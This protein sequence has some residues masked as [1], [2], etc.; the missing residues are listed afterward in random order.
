MPDTTNNLNLEGLSKLLKTLGLSGGEDLNSLI[1]PKRKP[2][3]LTTFL[4]PIMQL[5]GTTKDPNLSSSTNK[6]LKLDSFTKGVAS[7]A[8]SS[9]NPYAMAAGFGMSLIDNTFGKGSKWNAGK[10]DKVNQNI[11]G[12][13][14]G[15]N[16]T[17]ANVINDQKTVSGT[18]FFAKLLN[19]GQKKFKDFKN[20]LGQLKGRS[21]QAQGILTFNENKKSDALSSL[22]SLQQQINPVNY[23]SLLFGKDGL[24]VGL[25][26]PLQFGF[27]KDIK[28]KHERT[29]ES[30]MRNIQRIYGDEREQIDRIVKLR[31]KKLDQVLLKKEGG[32]LTAGQNVIVDGA[33]HSRK[34]NLGE[35]V[36]VDITHK[37]IPVLLDQGGE[38]K[39]VQEVEADEIIFHLELTKKIE[40][41]AKDE[42]DDQTLEA[43]KLLAVEIVKNTKDN[44]NKILKNE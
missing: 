1:S 20:Q 12:A 5:T 32:S 21:N 6:Q 40:A 15:L 37:G 30:T 36:E 28:R 22:D 17:Y 38:L 19:G 43:G 24:K 13:F 27:I 34:N 25:V 26:K 9:G 7:T 16:T 29:R 33:L 10:N 4:P 39:Q 23:D 44:K 3:D 31:Q 11:E 2:L 35:L 42:S 18:G 14:G 41:L 8:M